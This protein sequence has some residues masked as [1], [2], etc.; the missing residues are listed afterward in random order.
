MAEKRKLRLLQ[1]G[2]TKKGNNNKSTQK[3]KSKQHNLNKYR[4][5]VFIWYEEFCS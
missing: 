3:E 5:P 4:S 2:L 1:F